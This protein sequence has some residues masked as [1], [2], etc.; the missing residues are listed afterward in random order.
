MNFVTD[1]IGLTAPEAETKPAEDEGPLTKAQ[2]EV[3]TKTWATVETL[4]AET[5]GVILFEHIFRLAGDAAPD[6][7]KLFKFGREP[8]FDLTKLSENAGLRK[9]GEGVVKTVGVAVS[10]LT[11]L[12]ELVPVLKGLGKRHKN[13]GVVDA[14]YPVV[15]GA[16][17]ATLEQG[18]GEGYT[19][20]IA[21]AFGAMW[22]VVADTMKV[23]AAEE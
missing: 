5:V 4:G 16:L 18:L 10:M 8:D 11:K 14:H 6:L 23:G 7:A 19:P 1:A 9:H 15:G 17:L 2:V 22:G 12:D 13:Y 3:I 21:D 20:E